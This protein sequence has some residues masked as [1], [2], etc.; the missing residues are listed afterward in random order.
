MK[1]SG[2]MIS[3]VI[4]LTLAGGTA[5]TAPDGITDADRNC[6]AAACALQESADAMG[7]QGFRLTDY[8]VVFNDGRHD[9]VLKPDG[10]TEKRTP[11]I[12]SLAATAYEN[13]GRFEVIVPT[14]SSMGILSAIMGG[15]WSESDQAATIWHEAFHCWQLT[16]YREQ[17]E[18][19]TAGHTFSK[20]DFSEKLINEEYSADEKAKQLFTEQLELLSEAAKEQNIDNIRE[21]M[22]KY[23][24]LD[25]ARRELLSQDAQILENYYTIVE[26]TAFYVEMQMIRVQSEARFEKEYAGRLT[27]Y[28]EGSSKYYA[29]GG[30]ACLL[31][32]RIDAG[33]KT[34]YDFS[35]PPD[36]LIYKKLGV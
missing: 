6:Y 14:K 23:K 19:L 1:I 35:V 36:G 30:A 11:V 12:A 21:D 22:V 24:E 13:D 5:L 10:S 15:E 33:W 16:N 26:G 9:F 4:G 7:F 20:D 32:D 34:D 2:M 3:A 28:A 8:P 29:L 31:L 27:A 18:A 17:I 25:S